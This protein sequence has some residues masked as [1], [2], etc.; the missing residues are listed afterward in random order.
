MAVHGNGQTGIQ[1]GQNKEKLL[2]LLL[3]LALYSKAAKA[4]AAAV[5]MYLCVRQ[6]QGIYC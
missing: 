3:F 6:P 1:N 4:A 5:C 2:L